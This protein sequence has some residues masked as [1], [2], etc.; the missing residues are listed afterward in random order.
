MYVFNDHGQQKRDELPFSLK[1]GNNNFLISL[2][3]F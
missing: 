2:A 3:V 1:V